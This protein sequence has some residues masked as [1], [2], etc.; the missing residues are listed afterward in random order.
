MGRLTTG[1]AAVALTALLGAS[2]GANEVA[3]QAAVI[4]DGE[5]AVSVSGAPGDAANG[6]KVF[7]NR[8]QGNCLAC[9][10]NA[11]MPSESF[12]G[13]IGPAMDGVSLRYSE[14]QLRAI[15]VNSKAV[16]G[17]ETLMPGFYRTTGLQRVAKKFADKPILNAQQIEDVLAYLLTLNKEQ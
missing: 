17:E 3:P 8:K 14:A 13:Q 2:A 5:L 9:H 7:A 15:L 12:Q 4:V 11:D 6:A 10:A 1:V 16:F